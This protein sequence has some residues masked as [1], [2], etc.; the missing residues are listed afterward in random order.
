MGYGLCLEG[1]GACDRSMWSVKDGES[2]CQRSMYPSLSAVH[3]GGKLSAHCPPYLLLFL[4]SWGLNPEP[5]AR[6]ATYIPGLYTLTSSFDF[7]FS[8][9]P[10][11]IYLGSKVFRRWEESSLSIAFLLDCS[12]KVSARQLGRMP[13]PWHCFDALLKQSSLVQEERGGVADV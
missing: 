10:Q 4:Q 9:S 8:T 13:L 2:T 7:N 3:L 11:H 6:Q 1:T 5:S 12:Q